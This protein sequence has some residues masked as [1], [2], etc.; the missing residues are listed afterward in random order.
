[1]SGYQN[2]ASRE[3]TRNISLGQDSL[4]ANGPDGVTKPR[5]HSSDGSY[6]TWTGRAALFEF[7]EKNPAKRTDLVD[8]TTIKR[9]LTETPG[10]GPVRRLYLLEG[11]DAEH[12]RIFQEHFKIE[13]TFFRKHQRSSHREIHHKSNRTP[14]LPSLIDP[15]KMWCLDY[16]V[17]RWFADEW[18]SPW[19]RCAENGRRIELTSINGKLD[20]IGIVRRKASYWSEKHKDGGWD[21]KSRGSTPHESPYPE[22]TNSP[23]LSWSSTNQ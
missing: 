15:Q 13:P 9:C 17:L 1:M 12:A 11:P 18:D 8:V 5:T 16:Y 2:S 3:S 6:L 20:N 21:G 10:S 22:L 14:P 19:V 4:W 7:V 23:Q